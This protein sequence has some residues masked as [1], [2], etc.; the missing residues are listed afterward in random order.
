MGGRSIPA[1]PP[2]DEPDELAGARR[3]A[4]LARIGSGVLRRVHPGYARTSAMVRPFAD[5]WA[6][7]NEAAR[8]AAD[9]PLWVALGDSTGQ[10]IGAS[11]HDR[12]YVGGLLEWLGRRSGTAWR[13]VN[14]SRSGARVADV[15]AHQVPALESLGGP[16]DLVT[17]AVGAN[18]MLR[19]TPVPRLHATLSDVLDRLPRGAV[20]ATLPQGLGRRRPVGF[21]GLIVGVSATRGLVVAD[22]WRHTAPPWSGKFAADGFHPNDAGYRDWVAAFR[23]ALEGGSARPGGDRADS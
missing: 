20:V 19:R 9:G 4:P 3:P 10:G 12:G 1:G 13:V 22:V 18:D 6:A 23:E 8:A 2:P 5:A 7:A 15:L 17:L 14:L 11:A 21:N 16:P